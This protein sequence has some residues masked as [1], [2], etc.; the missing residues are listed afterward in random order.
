[1]ISQIN[2]LFEVQTIEE[3]QQ[4]FSTEIVC[5]EWLSSKKWADGYVCVKC[6]NTNYCKGTSILS[7]RC[8]R[9]KHNESVTANTA[10]HKCKIP[11]TEAFLLLYKLYD[12]PDQSIRKIAIN[13]EIRSMTC[14]RLKTKFDSCLKDGNCSALWA[15]VKSNEK[16]T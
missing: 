6:G 3:F 15:N 11:L 9:C 13:S 10:F 8:T 16:L 5:L 4:K 2:T 12:S 1:M 7:R 14:W